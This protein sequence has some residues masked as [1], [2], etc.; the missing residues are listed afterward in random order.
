MA[1]LD[2]ATEAKL[3]DAPHS[4]ASKLIMVVG[5]HWLSTVA[6]CDQLIDSASETPVVAVRAK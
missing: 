6:H 1:T 2:M 4:L 3:L 5:A